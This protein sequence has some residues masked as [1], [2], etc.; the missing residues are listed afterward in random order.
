VRFA[1][2]TVVRTEVIEVDGGHLEAD[3]AGEG[4]AVVL[5]HPGPW[6][7]RAWDD[8]FDVMARTFRA[9]R[10]DARGYGRSSRPQPGRRYSHVIDLVA[11]MDALDIERAALVGCSLGGMTALD[12]ALA[13]P[14]RV[15]A[16]V[17]AAPQ[18]S[19]LDEGTPAEEEWFEERQGAIDALIEAGELEAAQDLRLSSMWALLG[20]EDAAGARIRSI[21]LD[22]VHELTMDE[23]ARVD[24]NPPA[25]R[26]LEQVSVPTLVL[27]A[28]HDPP[29]TERICRILA[30]RIPNAR[31]VQIPDVDHVVNMR[32]P[33]EF[34]DAVLGFLGE[35]L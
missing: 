25:I 19:G 30:A 33:A 1:V 13:Y 9:V 26:R 8:Q 16:L 23:G 17:L 35:V 29:W 15:S 2:V 27:P 14:N 11:V 24:L 22:N 32:K 10:Y 18:V 4:S 12:C 21:A 6:D 34:N 7:R 31:R 3:V 5:L 28:D 20:T